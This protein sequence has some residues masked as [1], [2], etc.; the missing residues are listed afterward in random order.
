[1]EGYGL[2]CCCFGFDFVAIVSISLEATA[3]A[4]RTVGV[5]I[6]GAV[7][8]RGAQDVGARPARERCRTRRNKILKLI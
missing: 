8:A 6:W 3:M 2:C 4:M 1:V 7:G 5:E